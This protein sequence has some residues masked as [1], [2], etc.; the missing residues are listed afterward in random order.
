MSKIYDFSTGLNFESLSTRFDDFHDWVIQEFRVFASGEDMTNTEETDVHY[1]AEV[2]LRD[3]Y[4]R[5]DTT[6][7]ILHFENVN[8]TSSRGL[9]ELGSELSGI[10]FE[11]TP[12]GVNLTSSD[13]EFLRVEA[14]KLTLKLS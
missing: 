7:V 11:R 1:D 13:G 8:A 10:A 5:F 3:P 4:K 14:E 6:R 2:V 12:T 9:S